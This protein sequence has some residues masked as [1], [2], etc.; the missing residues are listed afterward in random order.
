MEILCDGNQITS[1]D[2]SE[3]K[4]LTYLRCQYN[5]LTL[6]NFSVNADLVYFLSQQSTHF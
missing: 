2:V 6:L 3:N 5:Q 1:L 4:E